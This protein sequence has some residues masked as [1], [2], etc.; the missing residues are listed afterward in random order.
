MRVLLVFILLLLNVAVALWQIYRPERECQVWPTADPG[1]EQLV[2]VQE[3]E[4]EDMRTSA[5]EPSESVATVEMPPASEPS[6]GPAPADRGAESR[7]TDQL[8]A[9]DGPRPEPA[10]PA[11]PERDVAT[12]PASSPAPP[13]PS[14]ACGSLG[15]F[16]ERSAA[17][18][19]LDVLLDQGID[20]H[21][22]ETAALVERYWVLLPP[23]SSRESAYRV[24]RRLR[25]QGIRDL[26]VLG[27]DEWENGISLGL[28][29]HRDTAQRR[30]RQIEGLGYVPRLEVL[31]RSATVFWVDYNGPA[32]RLDNVDW[33][34]LTEGSESAQRRPRD[35]P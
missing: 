24:E 16:A 6:G 4:R 5:P 1:V 26:Q 9:A 23:L 17:E 8:A 2:L 3:A 25:D 22:R 10:A 31:E 13:E 7:S 28:Y 19:A 12:A 27:A 11:P 34:A 21:I 32:E 33:A 29:R 20:G 15:S 18:S 35:C 14:R 30:L